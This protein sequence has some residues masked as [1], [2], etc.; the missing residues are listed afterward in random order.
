MELLI[1][2]LTSKESELW[3]SLGEA[4]YVPSEEWKGYVSPYRPVFMDGY[5]PSYVEG[6]KPGAPQ[7]QEYPNEEDSDLD[8][9]PRY[10]RGGGGG[11]GR[12]G[13]DVSADSDRNG[14]GR[15][16]VDGGGGFGG[17][18][19]R[20]QMAPPPMMSRFEQCFFKNIKSCF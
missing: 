13:S 7:G 12:R 1:N 8:R 17:H 20:P 6:G 14:G 11:G 16:V 2:C 3:H 19:G 10:N 15:D 18:G 5:S 4:W 9:P